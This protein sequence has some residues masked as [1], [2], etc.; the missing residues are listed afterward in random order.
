MS[1]VDMQRRST[2]VYA[3]VLTPFLD[4]LSA[5]E[6]R[7]ARFCRWLEGQG[8]GLAVFGTNSEANSLALSEK[9]RLLDVVLEAGVQPANLLPGTGACALPEAIAL[10]RRAEELGCHGVLVL[11]PFYYKP[12]SDGG[13]A[14]YYARL[15]EGVGLSD[16]RIYLYHIPQLSGVGIT[17]ALIEALLKRYSRNVVGIKDSSGDWNNTEGMLKLFPSL[18]IFPASEA[19]LAKALPLGAAG[20]ISAT[21]NL[22][23]GVIAK[24]LTSWRDDGPASQLQ[25]GMERVRRTMQQYPMIAALKSVVATWTVE[26]S[27]RL[28]RPP[29][30]GLESAQERELVAKLRDARFEMPGLSSPAHEWSAESAR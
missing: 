20:C 13:L 26:P 18:E 12:A 8:A 7:F 15:I 14:D 2:R 30:L 4:D 24:F 3:P 5:D 9:L 29:L 28:V 17:Y 16:L 25:V 22:Q 19:L 27:W 11:P 6:R 21:A 10:T 23:P 1:G